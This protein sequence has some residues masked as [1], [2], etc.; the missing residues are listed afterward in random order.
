M[1]DDKTTV[2]SITYTIDLEQ[3]E[4]KN[5]LQS[6]RKHIGAITDT[7]EKNNIKIRTLRFN[8]V[9]INNYRALDKDLITKLNILSTL[10]KELDV[11]WFDVAFNLVS[12]DNETV[13]SVCD[14]GLRILETFDNSFINLIVAEKYIN[15]F[16]VKSSAELIHEIASISPNGIDNF[17][18]GVSLNIAPNTPFFPFSYSDKVNSFSIAVETT[19]RVVD[20]IKKNFKHD[21]IELKDVIIDGIKDD[22]ILIEKTSKDVAEQL[23]IR[24]NGQD[25]S[26]SPYPDEDISVIE[27]LNLLG[28]DNFGSNGTQFLTSY[29]TS[30]LKETISLTKITAVGFNGVMYSLLEDKL[31]CEAHDK[32]NFSID[33]IILYSTVCGCG[34]DMV[35]LPGDIPVE[36]IASMILDVATT[37]IKLNKPLGV[38]VLPIK[39]KLSNEMTELELDFLT[40]TKVPQIKYIHIDK[41]IFKINKFYVKH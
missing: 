4:N 6:V 27:I 35:P 10:A 38:R 33:S 17:R 23:D 20:T 11:R 24:Y 31:M 41:S 15:N 16:A 29:L 21:Y 1:I 28:L 7:F 3:L 5:Y 14:M 34:L 25:I 9:A 2:R 37:S 26:L 8:T 39:N 40:N 18:F 36:E 30:I 22:L 12:E 19:K 32:G 13:K